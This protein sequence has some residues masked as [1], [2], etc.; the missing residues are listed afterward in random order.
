MTRPKIQVWVPAY[1]WSDHADRCPAD[2]AETEMASELRAAGRRV[3]IE[4]D[5]RQLETLRSDAAFYCDRYG[6]DE[7]PRALVR[8]ARGKLEALRKAASEE[9]TNPVE[10]EG[11]K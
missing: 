5:P 7:A 11:T 6:P 3:L 4:A 1:F 9:S 8:S 2:D 10:K